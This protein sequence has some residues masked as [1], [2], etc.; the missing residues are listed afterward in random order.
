MRFDRFTERAQDAATRA[1][2]IVRRYGHSQVDTEH[3]FLALLEQEDG[4]V[5]QILTALTADGAAMIDRLDRELRASPKVS[6]YGG[7]VGQVFY[8]PRIRTVLELSQGEAN[9]LKDEYISTE[10]I[11]LAILSERNTPSSRI[12]QEFG[13]TRER[14]LEAI[15][16]L[17]GGQRV[18]NRQAES[19]YRTLDKYSRDLTQAARD[20][21]LDPVIGRDSEILRVIQVLSRRTKNNPVLIGEAGVGKT[22]I[23]EGL[24]QKIITSDVPENLLNKRVVALDLGA[25][26]AGSRFRGEFEERLKAAMEEIQRAQGEIILFIDELHTVVGA[27]SAQGAMDA[28]N[29]LKPALARGELQCVGATTL[30][31]YRQYVER[32]AALERRF[33]PVFVDEP[34]VE[35]TIEM[36]HGLRGRYEAHHS[37]VFSP[38]A[39]DAAV[40]LSARYVTDR[41]LPDKAIDLMD[42]A[43]AKLRVALH[44]LPPGLKHLKTEIDALLAAEEEA[45]A[46]RDYERAQVSKADR[47]RLETEFNQLRESWQ[48]EQKLDEIVDEHDVAEVI[49]SWTGIPTSQMMETETVKLLEMEE[50]LHERIVGQEQA[51]AA[52]SDAIRRSRSGLS[53]PRRPIGSFIFLGSSGVGKTELAK[54]LAEFMF[55]DE[56][57]L[58]RVD[59]S[60]YREQHTVSRLFGAPPGYVGYEQGGQLTE[61]VRRR[62]YSVVLFDEI[63]KAHPDVWNALLQLLDDGRLTD[64][65]GRVVNFRNAVIVMTSNVGTSFVKKSG[66]LGFAGMAAAE[67]ENHKRIEEALKQT[68]R[69]EFINRIDEIIIFEPLTQ[70]NVVEIVKLQVKDVQARLAEHANL[71]IELTEPAQRW[72]AQQGLDKD[73]GARP[74]KRAIQRYVESALSIRLL[75]GEFKSGD[76]IRIDAD[77]DGLTFLLLESAPLPQPVEALVESVAIE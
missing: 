44:T 71:S 23:V 68:F 47:L 19:R 72:L 21:R 15:Q 22:A 64:G 48:S 74:L 75:K 42:E 76:R 77:D 24:A 35:E 58:I 51:I 37:V 29:M 59:M 53:D 12:V 57:A 34:S 70:E 5:P 46:A 49:A 55:D 54:A 65:Q 17:R 56:D 67:K 3:V 9:R 36:L 50:R 69:P 2:E 31:E 14:V 62:P 66:A 39:I 8:T 28:S 25:M 4:A 73:F 33:A 32:D 13:I 61:Q 43:A 6:V 40:K 11:F 30:D 52:L 63:E 10:H 18:T 20:G 7:G 38:A 16:E 27:G 60:E 41:R 1:Y 45:S 26:I